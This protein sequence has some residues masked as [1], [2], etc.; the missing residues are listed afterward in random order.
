MRKSTTVA[1]LRLN[2]MLAQFS[3]IQQLHSTRLAFQP[4]PNNKKWLQALIMRGSE[5]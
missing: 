2:N 4:I 5:F 3:V 1:Y